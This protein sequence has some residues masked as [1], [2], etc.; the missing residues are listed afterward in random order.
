MKLTSTLVAAASLQGLASAGSMAEL[1]ELKMQTW[2]AQNEAGVFDVDRYE[3]LAASTPCVNGKAGEYQCNKVD[4]ISF[5]RHQDMGSSTRKGNDIC[6]SPAFHL[7][8]SCVC[9]S[10]LTIL[11]VAPPDVTDTPPPI[12]RSFL[13]PRTPH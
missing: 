9:G 13:Y 6:E 1:R 2:A 3:A 4:L 7:S 11:V 5:L 10:F 12:Q 8:L